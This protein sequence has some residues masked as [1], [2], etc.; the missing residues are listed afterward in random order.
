MNLLLNFGASFN[1]LFG[2]YNSAMIL[3]CIPLLH[4]ELVLLSLFF[5]IALLFLLVSSG[6]SH[7]T[8]DIVVR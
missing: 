5:F 1:R 3:V 2:I 6:G 8:Q 7:I 4:S